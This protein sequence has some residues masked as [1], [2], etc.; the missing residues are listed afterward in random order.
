M[1]KYVSIY[2]LVFGRSSNQCSVF[3]QLIRTSLVHQLIRHDLRKIL[4][5][6]KFPFLI[7]VCAAI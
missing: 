5:K 3:D 7:I 4:I 6:R 2:N 1:E